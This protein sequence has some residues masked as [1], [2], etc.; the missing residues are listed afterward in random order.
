VKRALV[1]GGTGFI[2]LNL[3]DTLLEAGLEVRV[4]RRR[5]SITAFLR[6]RDVTMV[7]ASLEEPDALRRAMEGCDAVFLTAGHYPRY[8]ID[9]EASI[10][11]GVR[12]V[13]NACEAALEVGVPRFVYTSSIVSLGDAPEGR[14]ADERDVPSSM[15]SESVYRAVK[16]AME[17]EVERAVE[18]GLHAVTLLPGGCIGPWDVRLGTGGFLVGLVRGLVP[19]WTDGL[20][21]VVDIEDI[22]RAH[23]TAAQRAAPGARYCLSGHTVPVG[24]LFERIVS[25]FGGCMPHEELSLPDARVRADLEERAASQKKERVPFPREMVDIIGCGQPVSSEAAAQDLDFVPVS[26]ESSLDRAH[27]WFVRFRYLP[28]PQVEGPVNELR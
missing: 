11:T 17:R 23:L 16:W 1:I 18:R 14:P 10:E 22:A 13:R 7:E 3:V 19:W 2:G 6:K 5:R 15:P 26:L 20:V 9:R 8:S 24:E 25:R 27:A 4:T 28:A 21:H 12:G